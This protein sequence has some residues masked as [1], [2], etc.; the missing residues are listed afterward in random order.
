MNSQQTYIK[1]QTL[2]KSFFIGGFE[3]SS[4]RIRSGKR[5]DMLA[6]TQHDKYVVQDYLRL[7]QL[8][9]LTARSGVRWHLIETSPGHY[10][11]SSVLPMLE[12]AR[13]TGVQ[14]IWDLCHYGWPDDIDIFAPEFI[15]RFTRFVTAF[16]RLLANET[17]AIPFLCPMNEISFFAWAGGDKG[18][19]NPF[20]KSLGHDLKQQLGRAAIA[21][22]EAV[23]DVLPQARIVHAEPAI[24]IV[25]DP[26]RP[27]DRDKVAAYCQAQYQ[28][29]DMISGRLWPELGGDPKYLDIIGINYYAINQ[30]IDEGMTL[31]H[32]HPQYKPFR[33]IL[34]EIH[35]RYHRPMFIAETGTEGEA[36]ADW[37]NYVGSEVRA[38]IRAGL[39][40][41]G[42][43]LYP[44][45]NHPGWDNDRYCPNGLWDYVGEKGDREICKPL[46]H[47]LR[48]Q[49]RLFAQMER[50]MRETESTYSKSSQPWLSTKKR[51]VLCLFTDSHEP[52]G[53]GEHMLT[54]ASEL[55][56]QYY[57][58]F[59]CPPTAAGRQFL[60]R[61]T[62]LGCMV[63]GLDVRG[64]GPDW[65]HLC[66][67][68]RNLSVDIFH[69][70]AGIGWEGHDGVYAAREAGV[71][72]VLRTEHLPYL[73]T[74]HHQRVA[75]QYL[76]QAVDRLICVSEEARKSFLNA[77]VPAEKLCVVRNGILMPSLQPRKKDIR[78]ELQLSPTAKLMLTVARMTE[79][80]GHCYLIEA[81]PKIL[82][83]EPEAHFIWV[84]EGPLE[85]E[86]R[87]QAQ[88]QGVERHIHFLG[89]RNDV[90][91]LLG[92]SNL[93]VLP[94]L[95]EGLP[96]VVL[97]AL[98][99]GTP[100]VATRVCGTSEAVTDGFNGRLVAAQDSAALAAAI[101]E[102]LEQ[103][104]LTT[105]WRQNGQQ[106][107]QQEFSSGRMAQEI[108]A[109]YEA[110]RDQE[111]APTVNIALG[112]AA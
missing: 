77:K 36:R 101:T 25:P 20:Q 27:Q 57:V 7:Q 85:P 8:G 107:F 61:A 72:V 19:I 46:A 63:L 34:Q 74:D 84:G 37:L 68:L 4:H 94:S 38:A 98:A 100:V 15:W 1:D 104:Q 39:P 88:T 78:D 11:F 83:P 13:E 105:R 49:Q 23:W 45:L 108:T 28:A 53:M 33:N 6:T 97:E 9:L 54:L 112:M 12:A 26:R 86:L 18:Y 62:T 32:R 30:W 67:W 14:V 80:K 41:H 55:L 76:L 65:D 2:F 81:I 3:C 102:A 59:V 99:I 24:H 93:F 50:E 10:D 71:P 64:R 92:H 16:A 111:P 42:I 51:P 17:D 66:Y 47:E 75:H 69:G 40:L 96:L 44:I 56:K 91:A 21:G 31:N 29:W 109:V 103:P 95:F 58:L 90:P 106:R 110:L 43:C 52:S 87:R 60:E 82:E 70:H 35:E 89:R 48:R 73:L 79:Q 5:L 22:T